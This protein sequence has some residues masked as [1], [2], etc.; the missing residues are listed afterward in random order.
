MDTV[1]FFKTVNRLCKI[2]DTAQ[3]ALFVKMA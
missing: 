1:E 3:N 2:K